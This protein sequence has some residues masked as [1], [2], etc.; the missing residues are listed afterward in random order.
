MD[1][2]KKNKFSTDISA[3]YCLFVLIWGSRKSK[4][5]NFVLPVPT[6]PPW[7]NQFIPTYPP[8][9]ESDRTYFPPY[10]NQIVPTY[11]ICVNQIAPTYPKWNSTVRNIFNTR[12][13]HTLIPGRCWSSKQYSTII[14]I[15]AYFLTLIVLETIKKSVFFSIFF[16]GGGRYKWTASREFGAAPP[17]P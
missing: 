12:H 8:C 4:K 17:P 6:Y 11:P 5:W 15:W 10:G 1:L 14:V 2:L 9:V 7:W 13:M 16:L 3:K